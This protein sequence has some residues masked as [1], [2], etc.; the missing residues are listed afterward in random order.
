MTQTEFS[1]LIADDNEMNRWLLAEQC[2]HWSQSI[3]VVDDGLQAWELLRQTPYSLVFLDLNM[4]GLNGLEVAK[5]IRLD[6]VNRMTPIIAVTAH[7]QRHQG[8]ELIAEGFNDY[9]IKPLLLADLQRV[10][11]QW[12]GA[13][14]TL[15]SH[16]YSKTILDRV[17]QNH[18][19]GRIFLQKLLLEVPL[20]LTSLD[21]AMRAQQ[22]ATAL[23]LAHKLHGSFGFYGFADFRQLA[24]AL[25][26]S[27]MQTNPDNARQQF[28]ALSAK[29]KALKDLQ[30]ELFSQLSEE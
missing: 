2:Q 26:D 8:H 1:I 15:D 4:P 5:K 10:I 18:Q 29:F 11:T 17:A 24:G 13:K 30:S 3:A 16:Y 28:G 23:E 12:C 22:Q 14:V 19:L 20:L 21:E 27:L 7:L 25:E 6:S 9:L